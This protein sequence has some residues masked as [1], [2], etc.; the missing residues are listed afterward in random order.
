MCVDQLSMQIESEIMLGMEKE[1]HDFQSSEHTS[2][3]FS[4]ELG[5]SSDL[6]NADS[7]KCWHK[8]FFSNKTLTLQSELGGFSCQSSRVGS[9]IAERIG[10]RRNR[11]HITFFLLWQPQLVPL[12]EESRFIAPIIYESRNSLRESET[13]LMQSE[14]ELCKMR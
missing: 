10:H 11:S 3:Y 13:S 1:A 7:H 8:T 5:R 12:K 4:E 2:L 14:A 6:M 9:S